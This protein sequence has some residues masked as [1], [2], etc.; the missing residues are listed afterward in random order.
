MKVILLLILFVFISTQ[1]LP[2]DTPILKEIKKRRSERHDQILSCI[3]ENGSET[4]KKVLNDNKDLKFGKALRQNKE[5]I[6]EEDKR[7]FRECRKKIVFQHINA[8]KNVLGYKNR[9]KKKGNS[10]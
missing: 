1:S 3:N 7:V 9:N 4:L 5:S 8:T 2:A 10:P 6:T